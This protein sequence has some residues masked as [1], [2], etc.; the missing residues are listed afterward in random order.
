M[1]ENERWGTLTCSKSRVA[2]HESSLLTNDVPIRTFVFFPFM[3]TQSSS[4]V[5]I[6]SPNCH[7]LVLKKLHLIRVQVRLK[8]AFSSVFCVLVAG[9]CCLKMLLAKPAEN[10]NVIWHTS[11]Y[12]LQGTILMLFCWLLLPNPSH[13]PVIN[14]NH[15]NM[16]ITRLWCGFMSP[17]EMLRKPV[18][19][20]SHQ[21]PRNSAETKICTK[22]EPR[23]WCFCSIH[24]FKGPNYELLR[25][26]TQIRSNAEHALWLVEKSCPWPLWAS[27]ISI[28]LSLSLNLWVSH[29][30]CVHNV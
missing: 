17:T 24:Q 1:A 15:E 21:Q 19:H 5:S 29:V 12:W 11:F 18:S 7:L 27:E 4:T 14:L 23:H 13:L 10:G 16:Q 28:R 8:A 26:V 3:W 6:W 2:E 30:T 22:D 25:Q 20:R 9:S